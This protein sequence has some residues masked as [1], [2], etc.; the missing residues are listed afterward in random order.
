[1]QREGGFTLVELLVVIL[2]IGVLVGMVVPNF[3][4][5]VNQARTAS[6]QLNMRT[7][8][9]A[10]TAYFAENGHYADDFYEDGYGYIFD[11]GIRDQTLG[12]FPMNPF[13]GKT[14]EPDDFNVGD[15]DEMADVTSTTPDGPNDDWGYNAGEMRYQNFTPLG[16]YYPSMWG[17]IGFDHSGFTI[18]HFTSE[19]DAVLFVLFQ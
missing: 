18:R 13:T 3:K 17:L 19:G 9:T 11:G 14:M 8:Q 4:V 2:I 6:V 10:V 16:Q 15:Y 5:A 1:M 12:A 7:V